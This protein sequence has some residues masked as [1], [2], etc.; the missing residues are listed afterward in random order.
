M[1]PHP[2]QQAAALRQRIEALAATSESDRRLPPELVAEFAQRGWFRLCVPASLGGLEADPTTLVETIETVARADGSAAWCVM[3]GATTGVVAAYLDE[4]AAREIYAANPLTV[5]GGVFAPR[6][7]AVVE[8]D[9]YRI[10]GRWPFASGCQ[11]CDWLMGGCLVVEDGKPR[12]Q[13]NGVPEPIMMMFP[14]S[15]ATVHDTWHVAGLRGTGSHD[16]EVRDLFVP[17]ER[18]VALVSGEPRQPGA[19]YAFPV[20]GLLALGIAGVA[21]GIARAALDDLASLAATKQ[22]GASRRVLAERPATQCSFARAEAQWRAA[23]TFLY[24]TIDETWLAART[25]AVI[26]LER[27]ALLRLAASHATETAAGVVD[28]LYQLGGG[29]S[30]YETSRLQRCF[31]D[32]HVATQHMM[33]APATY[34]LSG[35]F[36]LGLDA[37]ASQL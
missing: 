14:A 8:G 1:N 23:R 5:T 31:R 25:D 33:V 17:R 9:G 19:L 34:E 36:L 15:A 24:A 35:R 29:S 30:I 22:P 37:D 27:R 12:L 32:V 6:G 13:E 20:F 3:I 2:P 26:P 4:A 11:H 21:L 10:S 18:A 7:K 16:I 28:T